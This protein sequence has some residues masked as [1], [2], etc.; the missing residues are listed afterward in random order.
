MNPGTLDRK[1][2]LQRQADGLWLVDNAGNYVVDNTGARLRTNTRKGRFGAEL[3]AWGLWTTRFARR[4][5]KPGQ[6][7]GENGRERT[8]G[9]VVFKLRYTAGLLSSDRLVDTSDGQAYDIEDFIGDL[10]QGWME[11]RCTRY[12]TPATADQ[13]YS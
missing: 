12:R 7:N 1:I 8:A 11:I 13:T 2:Q 5:E 3:D 4:I 6:E 9:L 10:R